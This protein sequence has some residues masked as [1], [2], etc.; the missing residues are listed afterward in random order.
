[1]GEGNISVKPA[2]KLRRVLALQVLWLTTI[3]VLGIWWTTLL[4][5]QARRIAELE[6]LAGISAKISQEAWLKTNRML[7][8]ESITFYGLVLFVT[9]LLFWMHWREV[10]RSRSFQAFFA[11]LTHE[12]RT[13]LTSI[14]LQ[15][16]SI[17]DMTK[18]NSPYHPLTHRLLEDVNRIEA[19]VDRTLELARIEGGG[20]VFLSEIKLKPWTDTF[21]RNEISPKNIKSDVTDHSIIAD[22]NA[23]QV[24]FKNL[25]ENSVRHSNKGSDVAI[26]ISSRAENSEWIKVDY[27][28]NG[29]GF[30]GSGA[31]LAEL[32]EKGEKSSGAGVGL[33][34]VQNLMAKIGGRVW[35]HNLR[36][37]VPVP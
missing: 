28:D 29:S 11:S 18:I 33:Y 17:A 24:V 30:S 31:R 6:G 32:F 35:R 9:G 37:R 36:H 1:M 3:G 8:W 4:L 26:K 16:E 20:R 27:I 12:L 22:P 14:R 19:Q 23:V 10:K 21:I 25:V 2:K 15:A 13:P 5:H 7:F 34:L